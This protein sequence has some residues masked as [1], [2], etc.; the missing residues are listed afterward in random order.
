MHIGGLLKCRAAD[1]I[2]PGKVDSDRD[3]WAQVARLAAEVLALMDEAA[4][5]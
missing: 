2:D 5:A 1:V 4:A 3:R